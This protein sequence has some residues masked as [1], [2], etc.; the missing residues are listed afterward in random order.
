MNV[1]AMYGVHWSV[2]RRMRRCVGKLMSR[3]G[4]KCST[5]FCANERGPV[6]LPPTG[7][8]PRKNSPRNI[9]LIHWLFV[10]YSHLFILRLNSKFILKEGIYGNYLS[11]SFKE[12]YSMLDSN[13]IK[14]EQ[15]KP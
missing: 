7:L 2:M 13:S 10:K 14:A 3:A 6:G 1:T 8:N 4:K 11:P 15:S 12:G 9:H 5:A